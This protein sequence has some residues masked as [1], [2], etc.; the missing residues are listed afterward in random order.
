MFVEQ[1][2]SEIVVGS[3]I[4][5][6][7]EQTGDY[8]L[9]GPGWVKSEAVIEALKKKGIKRLLVDPSKQRQ[10]QPVLAFPPIPP[11]I[12]TPISSGSQQPDISV[13][14]EQD[15]VLEEMA[16]AKALFSA[17]K[18]LQKKV[19]EDVKNGALIDLA[20]V[21]ELTDESIDV[22]FKNS[23]ALAC[24]INLRNKDEYLL[25]HSIAVSMLMAFFARHLG[26]DKKI[27]KE[28]AIGAFLHDVGKIRTP[29]HIL[30]K[31]GKL[32]DAEFEIMKEHVKHSIDIIKETPGISH[33][34][35]KVAALHHERLNGIG[36]PYGLTGDKISTYGRMIAICDVFDALTANR[37]YKQGYS[38]LKSLSILRSLAEEGQLDP[39]LVDS[40]IRCMGVYPVGS[41]VRLSSD[42]L[43]IVEHKNKTDPIRPKVNAFYCLKNKNFAATSRI[44]LAGQDEEKILQ[45]VRAN[46]FD[47]DMEQIMKYL[48][49]EG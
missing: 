18:K 34:S 49:S 26:I 11:S 3:Y 36:Y 7:L 29:D 37:C 43:A 12:M 17:S 39:L 31:P 22:I 24:V 13:T 41:L 14:A 9:S 16:E 1:K 5:K 32:T 47:L 30:H 2:I 25:E 27:I 44:D 42:R 45:C 19:F 40:F 20:P 46:D 21:R 23:D 38:Q 28:L 35:L 48:A 4:V 6:I 10:Q 33:L 15:S 8:H